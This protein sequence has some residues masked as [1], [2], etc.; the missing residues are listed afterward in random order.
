[1]TGYNHKRHDFS[2]DIRGVQDIGNRISDYCTRIT[3]KWYELVHEL[4]QYALVKAA[5]ESFDLYQF[6]ED[7]D[8][9]PDEFVTFL[10]GEKGEYKAFPVINGILDKSESNMDTDYLEDYELFNDFVD[11]MII[12]KLYRAVHVSVQSILKVTKNK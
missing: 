9:V 12:N 4:T 5:E 1:M 2:E 11:M 7:T 6:A 3:D 10:D 8:I